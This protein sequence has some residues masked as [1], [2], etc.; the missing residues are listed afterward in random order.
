MALTRDDYTVAWICA[1][2]VEMAAAKTMLDEVHPSLPQPRSDHNIY[3][4]GS[5]ARHNIV[6]ACLPAGVYGTISATAVVS[7]MMS[8][9]PNIR[10]GLMV[11]IGGGV[12]SKENDV[13]LGDVVVSKPT[14]TSSGVIQYDYGKTV[15][16]GRFQHTGSLNK[17]PPLL[18][19]GVAQIESDY[20][21]GKNRMADI[22][23]DLLEKEELQRQFARPQRDCLF[24]SGY[25]HKESEPDCSTCDPHQLEIRLNVRN[26]AEPYIHYGLIASGDQVI[27]DAKTRDFIAKGLG[28]MCFEMEAAGLMD[29]LPSIVIRGICDYCDSH[30]NKEWQG[31]AAFAAAAYTKSL[32]ATIPIHDDSDL[33]APSKH[34]W[35]VP[36]LKN[37]GFVGRE[38]EIAKIHD[39]ITQPNGPARIAICGLGGVGKTQIALEI[40][41]SIHESN[42]SCSIF[43]IS[44]TSYESVEQGYMSIAQMAGIH[45]VEPAEVKEQ[46]KTHFS[47]E[48]AG[49]WLMIFD[50]ADDMDMWVQDE[51]PVLTDF[52]PQSAKGHI[53][54]TTRNRKIAVKLAS[55][56]VVHISE[57][58]PETAVNILRNSLIDKDLLDD[59][60]GTQDLLKQLV[61]LPLAIIQAAAYINEN[62]ITIRDY[63]SLLSEQEPDLIELLSEDFQDEGRY[64]N[65]QN[66]VATTWLIS[67]QQIQHLNPLAAEY[68]SFM[69]CVDPRDIPLSLL[70]PTDSK[71]KRTDAIGLLKAFSFANGQAGDHAL[72]IHRLVHLSTRSWLRQRRELGLQICKTADRFKDVF[73]MDHH[74]YRHLWRGYLPHAL[75]LIGEDEFQ[76]QQQNYLGLLR[77][78]GKCL[79]SDGRYDEA[80]SLFE[81][82]MSIRR[83]GSDLSDAASLR[84]LAD[85][86]WI[87]NVQGR[88]KEALELNMQSVHTSKEVLGDEHRSTLANMDHLAATFS[89]LGR[90]NEAEVLRAEITTTRNQVLGA[91]HPDTL[92]SMNNLASI[93]L[94]QG[95]LEEAEALQLQ[96]AEARKRVLGPEH[97]HTL[98]S[99]NH[100]V[101]I[102]SNQR[103]W[104]EAEELGKRV[105][106]ARTEILGPEH[107]DTLRSFNNLAFIYRK[108]GRHKEAE[109]LQTQAVE[110]RVRI[111]GPEHPSTLTS[112]HSLASIYMNQDRWKEADELETR[113]QAAQKRILGLEHPDTMIS[114]NRLAHI[115]KFLGKD[116]DAIGLMETCVA[117][118]TKILGADHGRTRNCV[119]DLK[120]WKRSCNDEEH[121][122]SVDAGYDDSVTTTLSATGITTPSADEDW[123]VPH[124]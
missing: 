32:L 111:L 99:M 112:M 124:P 45:G 69:A 54:F 25:N 96:L 46:V 105:A 97:P 82:I 70:P 23:A 29:E 110:A 38:D 20:M 48:S 1:L 81:N 44:C 22:M 19:K 92:R 57:P 21:A 71:K 27:K 52:L 89:K 62:D 123:I 103:R 83:S 100:L 98:N 39:L 88:W 24:K 74:N 90:W 6:V 68:L 63:T 61:F 12:P 49:H 4:L 50:N 84:D 28:I 8:T 75:S 101:S 72:S 40:T 16:D 2:P 115:R 107:P 116:Q 34:H 9:Y 15:R 10:F 41:Y 120:E 80:A 51:E 108:D 60:D 66:P 118:T 14:G 64:Q 7:H 119:S 113:V 58:G 76:N 31:Y 36:F 3:T 42:P 109:V 86:G 17:P 11:G 77:K 93:Y 87:Y 122:G 104:R 67:F 30:K 53:L 13:R 26:E 117:L 85:L 59:Y 5:V 65:I 18:L 56:R 91:E 106:E 33:K 102:Y 47:Q 78:I 79:R 37:S 73:P 114:M 94:K 55:S 95:R 43:W 35:M 121:G